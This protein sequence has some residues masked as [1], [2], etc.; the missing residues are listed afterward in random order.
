MSGPADRLTGPAGC[1]KG[2]TQPA[3]FSPR[4]KKGRM[5]EEPPSGRLNAV[6]AIGQS[7]AGASGASLVPGRIA[8]PVSGLSSKMIGVSKSSPATLVP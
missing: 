1:A 3:G 7:S 4:Q 5:R 6:I 8:L 2:W